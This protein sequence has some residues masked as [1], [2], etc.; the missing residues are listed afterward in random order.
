MP[1]SLKRQRRDRYMAY[2]A[3]HLREAVLE[4]AKAVQEAG[5]VLPDKA[6]DYVVYCE[7]IAQAL[8]KPKSR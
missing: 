8:P 2:P 6:R 7:R 4:L 1:K 5:I 3:A